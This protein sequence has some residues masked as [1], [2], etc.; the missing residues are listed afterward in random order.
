MLYGLVN[1]LVP[2]E[3]VSFVPWTSGPKKMAAVRNEAEWRCQQLFGYCRP[4]GSEWFDNARDCHVIQFGLLDSKWDFTTC[5]ASVNSFLEN[6][7]SSEAR[8][9]E[10]VS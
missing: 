6:Y 3:L 8:K 9:R 10:F 1:V 2:T 4:T 5:E 7:T